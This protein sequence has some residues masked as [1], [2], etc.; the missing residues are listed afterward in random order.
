MAI[1]N[2]D[3]MAAR[4]DRDISSLATGDLLKNKLPDIV[5]IADEVIDILK[6]GWQ[7]G[8]VVEFFEVIGPLLELVN[9]MSELDEE[10]KDQFIVDAVW[11]IYQT[12]DTYPDGNQNNIDIPIVFG[13]IERGLEKKAVDFA[14][15][16]SI[17]AIRAWIAKK[18][19]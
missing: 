8:D 4:V 15:R 11:M 1:S 18:N 16:S 9:D 17:K 3:G 7:L 2:W 19:G 13:G 6:D 10:Q 12:V 14:A 5:K